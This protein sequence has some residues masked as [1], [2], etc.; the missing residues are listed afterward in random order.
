MAVLR[1]YSD[2]VVNGRALQRAAKLYPQLSITTELCYNVELTGERVTEWWWYWWSEDAADVDSTAN[3]KNVRCVKCVAWRFRTHLIFCLPHL[4]MH[5]SCHRFLPL[6]AAGCDGLQ[7]EQ[8]EVLLWLFRPPL[9]AEPLSEK[10]NLTEGS[11]EKLVEIGP[12]YCC[13]HATWPVS[14]AGAL[15]LS[16]TIYVP[17]YC[18][19]RGLKIIGSIQNFSDNR[20]QFLFNCQ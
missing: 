10:S 2:E 4:I 5:P 18:K 6:S 8:K 15:I 17:L 1:F 9:Q 11:G 12:R 3:V 20:N 7:A 13:T 16:H 14:H 19:T